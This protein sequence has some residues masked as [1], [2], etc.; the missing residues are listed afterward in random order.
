MSLDF[1]VGADGSFRVDAIP[2]GT[3]RLAAWI[4]K[5]DP[6]DPQR[7]SIPFVGLGAAA[8]DLV[9]EGPEDSTE[10]MP[11]DLGVLE[12]KRL[13]QTQAETQAGPK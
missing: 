5:H 12:V 13:D 8:R 2:E 9:V 6:D 11:L 10:T 4:G 1:A 7:V 3:Y